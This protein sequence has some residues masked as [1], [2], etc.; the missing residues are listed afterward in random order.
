MVRTSERVVMEHSVHGF[1]GASR[2]IE[3]ACPASIRMSRGAENSTNPAAELGTAAHELGEFCL[4]FGLNATDGLGLEFNGHI[5]DEPMTQASAVYVL[6]ARARELKYGIKSMLE[7]RVLMTSLGRTDVFG[8]SDLIARVGRK[9]FI[10]DYK[11]GYGLVEVEGNPQ[12]TGY[13]VSTLD[14]FGWWNEIDE[15]E[16]TVIQPRASHASGPIRSVTYTIDEMR[17][18]QQKFARSVA[19]T[20]DKNQKPKAGSW[21][22]YCPARGN[23]RARMMLTLEIAY[24]DCPENE[25]SPGEIEALLKEIDGV[26]THI[27]ALSYRA[28]Q[29]GRAGHRFDGYK[30]VNSIVRASCKDEKA[31]VKD[32]QEKGIDITRLF[33]QKLVSMTSARKVLPAALINKHYIKP[34]ASTTLVKL[35]DSR[36]ALRV[37][38]AVGIFDNAL[39]HPSAVDIFNGNK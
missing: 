32:A 15:I 7:Q 16:C 31:L 5:V 17:I 10:D 19:L 12:F 9:L 2:W 11:H 34:P 27:E 25:L 39:P 22:K 1:S 6:H 29:L 13:A 38:S 30:L 3:D 28:L 20:E 23:C 35:T 37:G 18:W 8:T 14:T 26:K 24:R 4:K 21:C 33:E 36:P